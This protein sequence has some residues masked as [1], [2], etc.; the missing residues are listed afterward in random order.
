MGRISSIKKLPDEVKKLI[1][2]LIIDDK[3]TLDEIVEAINTEFP[4]LETVPSRVAVWR[5]QQA[6]KRML[7]NQKSIESMST[8][9]VANLGDNFDDKTS[10]L[11]ANM[12]TNLASYAVMGALGKDEI[13]SKELLELARATNQAIEASQKSLKVRRA[14]EQAAKDKLIAEQKAKLDQLGKS[15]EVPQEMLAKVIKAAYGIET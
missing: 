13:A 4:E 8:T 15:G 9:L 14:I 2:K 10:A 7:D 6:L 12:M 5:H 3:F 11:L 1:N